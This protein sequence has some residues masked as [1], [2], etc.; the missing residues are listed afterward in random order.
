MVNLGGRISGLSS[1]ADK[2]ADVDLRGNLENQSPLRIT[3]RIN[4]LRDNLFADIK[5]S[6]TDIELSPLTP[7]SG[8]FLG[9]TVEKGKLFLDLKYHIENK[10][11]DSENKVFI[12]QFTFGK[13]VESDKATALPVRLAIALLK[14]RKGEI[15]LDL[16]V[17]GMTD[18]PKFSVWGVVLQI[19]KNLLVKAA[20][21][22]FALLQSVFGGKDDFSG[23]AFS[24]GSARLS[25]AER[26]KL[27]KLGQVLID[28]PAL[29]LEVSGFVDRERDPEGY[30]NEL[31]TKKIKSEKFLA[32]VKEKKAL[33]G[34][35]ADNVEIPPQEYPAL[36][37]TVYRKEKFP[38]PRNF[39]GLVKDLPADEMKKLILTHT[40]VGDEAL[41]GLAR[42]RA[43]VVRNF[44]IT[45]GKLPP[46][47]IFE[48]KGDIFKAPA[49]EGESA[50]RVEFGVAAP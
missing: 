13:K 25:D 40:V 20:T 47:R 1:A 18:D 35:S 9:Y 4:P 30:R 23:V 17:T 37:K 10:K 7:Y 21:S 16:P 5:V 44:L 41:Q 12:D 50:S 19:L 43:T 45:Q 29:K 15:H 6:F 32:L 42:D 49:K 27:L 46:E 14:D 22:P 31:L 36:L 48:K 33:E 8:T 28:R 38:K 3:G 24:P 2:L 34:Q 11:L 26:A 39:I